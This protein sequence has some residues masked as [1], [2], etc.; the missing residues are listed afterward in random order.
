MH[1]FGH[2]VD[3]MYGIISKFK[4]IAFSYIILC[5]VK[6]IYDDYSVFMKLCS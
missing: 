3:S 1:V 5:Q 6:G 4:L 2:P